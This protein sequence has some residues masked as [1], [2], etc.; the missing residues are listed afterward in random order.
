MEVATE[1]T[2]L[3]SHYFGFYKETISHL[4]TLLFSLSL[5]LWVV[6]RKSMKSSSSTFFQQKHRY[7]KRERCIN[8]GRLVPFMFPSLF[9]ATIFSLFLLHS[10]N[11]LAIISKQGLDSFFRH[12][13]PRGALDSV[14][15]QPMQQGLDSVEKQD[16][17]SFQEHQH[18]DQKSKLLNNPFFL[19]LCWICLYYFWW[20]GGESC[21]RFWTCF[22]FYREREL[23]LV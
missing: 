10:P 16:S 20:G 14:P 11:P 17:N 7:G 8:M 23:W 19:A 21:F 22:W 2:Q 12:E 1:F 9:I 4:K 13:Q 15:E 5:S 6:E 18:P 3:I